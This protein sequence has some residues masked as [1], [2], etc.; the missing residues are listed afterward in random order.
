MD[1]LYSAATSHGTVLSLNL[2]NRRLCHT[3]AS[4]LNEQMLPVSL[5][6][7]G[8]MG[9]RCLPFAFD[10]AT[11]RPV[12]PRP[13][14]PGSGLLFYA[15]QADE[16]NAFRCVASGRYLAA[17][18]GGEIEGNRATAATWEQ[19]TVT[20]ENPGG[21]PRPHSLEHFLERAKALFAMTVPWPASMAALLA[22]APSEATAALVEGL[23]PLLTL[24]ELDRL[25]SRLLQD[26]A[27]PGRLARLFPADFYA[28]QALPGLLPVMAGETGPARTGQ[29]NTWSSSWQWKEGQR[30]APA[31]PGA[32]KPRGMIGP[33]LD[34]L[35][36]DGY[37]GNLSSFAHA[38]N[39]SLRARTAPAKG[40]AIVATARSEGVY[41]LEWIAYHR[42]IGVEAIFLYTNNNDDGSD[43]LLAALHQAGMITWTSS[44][45]A[46][47]ASAQNKAYGHAL[48]V[49]T[50]LLEHGWALFIDLDE[51]LVLNPARYT[52]VADFAR[53]HEMRQTD[54][55]G[56]NWVMVGSSGELR[57]TEAPLTRR[58]THLLNEPNAHIKVMMAPRHFIQAHPHFPFA[59]RRRSFTFRLADGG[60]HEHRKQPPDRY[61]ARAFSDEP[62]S[63]H[64]CLYHYNFKS[65]D[66]FA[67]KVSRN[68]GDFPMT[69]EID[70][71]GLDEV[72]V[73][74]FV[75]QHHS[76][77][78]TRND[79][80]ARCAPGMD[81]ELAR[82]RALP[83][84]L[85]AERAVIATFQERLAVIKAH[86]L[87][88]PRL[89]Q[90]GAAG[91]GMRTLLQA[92]TPAA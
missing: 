38:C 29:Q 2:A 88:D 55:V 25:A 32:P 58:N 90:L 11:F 37:D 4:E 46:A 72:A 74:S 80:L 65:V 56:I 5:L 42:A 21:G 61:H 26:R 86:L 49:N 54:A 3:P 70:F 30:P 85:Q 14:S 31:D 17:I 9:A 12:V 62:S 67:W 6:T 10:P 35:A 8:V 52:T 15:R 57:W 76:A 71:Q 64:A 75:G 91:E 92:A 89:G 19:F 45:L 47:G 39:A 23:W 78:I 48:N 87:A 27:L 16:P 73:G 20:P 24:P 34:H 28:T 40:V 50:K 63:E 79:R 66:E 51:F 41:L 22:D 68:R 1:S 81:A 77:D 36:R 60:L 82:L 7:G 59:D 33:E 84:V 13:V 18:P 43:A 69:H 53:W 83:G 44:V